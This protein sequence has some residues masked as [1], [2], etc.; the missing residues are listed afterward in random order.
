MN[1]HDDISLRHRSCVAG[2]AI[3]Q[4]LLC[5]RNVSGRTIPDRKELYICF[6][7]PI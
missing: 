6:D 3:V 5:A 1:L 4:L 7:G 2:T